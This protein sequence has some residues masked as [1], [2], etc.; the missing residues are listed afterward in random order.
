MS[1]HIYGI[2]NALVDQEYEVQD[3]FFQQAGIE[4]G[5]MTLIDEAQ[6]RS[7]RENLSAHSPIKHQACGGSAANSII[8]AS[9]LGAKTFYSCNV[10]ND[11]DGDFYATDLQAAG[12]ESN[13]NGNRDNGVTGKC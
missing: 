6:M 8:A 1:Y 3:H 12:V 11:Q 13:I 5:I 4:K 10:A 9:Y 2:G 7:L